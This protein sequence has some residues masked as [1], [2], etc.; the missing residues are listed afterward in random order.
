MGLLDQLGSGLGGV[1]GQALG[2]IEAQALPAVLSKVLGKTD[3]GDVNGLLQKLQQGG[4]GNQVSSWLGSGTNLPVSADQLKA[5]L[6]N[7]QLQQLAG[8][9]GLPVD[10]ILGV[11]AQH[12]PAAVDQMS[13]K[14]VI[15][16][17]AST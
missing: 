14:G 2:Q 13:P 1:L 17:T 16:D 15:E 11:L 9:L 6:G 4:L 5:A 10:K 12:L 3:L 8:A 7:E